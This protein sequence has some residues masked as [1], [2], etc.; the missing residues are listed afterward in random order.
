MGLCKGKVQSI[1]TGSYILP[2]AKDKRSI[3]VSREKVHKKEREWEKSYLLR[4]TAYLVLDL[5]A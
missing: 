2:S 1:F 3:S 5:G 4:R